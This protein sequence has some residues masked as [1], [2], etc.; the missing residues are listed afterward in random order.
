MY[1]LNGEP[2]KICQE[3]VEIIFHPKKLHVKIITI[4]LLFTTSVTIY[5][6]SAKNN[7]IIMWKITYTLYIYTR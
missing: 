7:F 3:N 5:Y 1:N 2:H 6:Y 4:V